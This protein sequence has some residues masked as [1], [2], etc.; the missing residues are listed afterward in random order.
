MNGNNN[1][2]LSILTFFLRTLQGSAVPRPKTNPQ[3]LHNDLQID[4]ARLL[5]SN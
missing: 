3:I 1:L 5:L 2:A 4:S